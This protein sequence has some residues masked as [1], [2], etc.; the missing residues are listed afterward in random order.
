MKFLLAVSVNHQELKG[1]ILYHLAEI[2]EQFKIVDSYVRLFSEAD[3]VEHVCGVYD[4]FNQFLR[5]SIEWCKENTL[6]KYYFRS[7][8]TALTYSSQSSSSRT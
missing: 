6:G 8:I 7:L 4:N 5:L 3:M 2:G 1:K